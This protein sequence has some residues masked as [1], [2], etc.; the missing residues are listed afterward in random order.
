MSAD[1][2]GEADGGTVVPVGDLVVL[3]CRCVGDGDDNGDNNGDD[4][5]ESVIDGE[6]EVDSAVE[7]DVVGIV[8]V[9]VEE[10]NCTGDR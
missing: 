4:D 2:V 9:E 7:G 10:G 1:A 5:S 8:A 3:V 6:R